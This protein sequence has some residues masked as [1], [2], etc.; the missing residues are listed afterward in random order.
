M[1]NFF[2]SC[3]TCHF[4]DW[5][6]VVQAKQAWFSNKGCIRNIKTIRGQNGNIRTKRAF[7]KISNLGPKDKVLQ[8]V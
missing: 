2:L 7:P 1:N 5:H 8:R 4:S 3:K 6:T